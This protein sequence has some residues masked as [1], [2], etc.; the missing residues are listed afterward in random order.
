VG[1]AHIIADRFDVVGLAGAGGAASVYRATDRHSGQTVAVKV[2][3]GNPSAED[4]ERFAREAALLAQF[5]HPAIVRYVTHGREE[6]G[7]YLAMEWLEGMTL[8]QRLARKALSIDETLTLVRGLAEA[9]GCAHARGMVHRDVKPGNIFLV[10][11]EAEKVKLL[12]FGIARLRSASAE[13]TRTGIVVGTPGYMA[14][15]Q[16]RGDRDIDARGDVFSLGC[17]LFRCLTGK[18]AFAG[19]DIVAVLTKVLLEDAP[20]V[21]SL[22]PDV[23]PSLDALVAQMLAKR[24]AD[25][26]TDANEVLAALGGASGSRDA[27]PP[28]TAFAASLTTDE[29][30]MM[31]ILLSRPPSDAASQEALVA[32]DT[33][34]AAIA[35]QGGRLDVLADRSMLVTLEGTGTPTDSAA[36]AA[37]CALAIHAVAPSLPVVL[38]AGEGEMKGRVAMGPVIDR[39]AALLGGVDASGA[40]RIDEVIA[41]FLDGRFEVRIDKGLLSIDR[42]TER[43]W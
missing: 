35:A 28:T 27:D 14:P 37:R 15:E 19:A 39:G 24:P 11:G 3:R 30:R 13:I 18:S 16:A 42:P 33:L 36:R 31:C 29:R 4:I 1:K 17:V 23:S 7:L 26:P 38:V 6:G 43:R 10:D 5:S 22:R 20:P 9:L 8:S 2:L 21:R 25:R 40:V 32:S 12:D 41:G 34:R